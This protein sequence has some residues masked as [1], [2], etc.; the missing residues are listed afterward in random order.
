[1]YRIKK[2]K[3]RPKPNNGPY[4]YNNNNNNNNNSIIYVCAKLNNKEASYKVT[5]SEKVN[6]QRYRQQKLIT[7]D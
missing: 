4:S 6:T 7:S 3:R 2:L 5:M 1:V